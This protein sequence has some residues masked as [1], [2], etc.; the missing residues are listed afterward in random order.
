[1][2]TR[3]LFFTL[4][5]ALNIA[6]T[7]H[8]KKIS[9]TK[10]IVT[11]KPKA[12]KKQ[13]AILP[14]GNINNETINNMSEI[15]KRFYT[16]IEI[17][18]TVNFPA[19]TYYKPRNRYRADSLI[20]WMSRIAKPN[21]TIIGLTNKDISTTSGQYQDWGVMGLG[22]CPGN[23]CVSSSYRLKNKNNFWKVAIHELG[24]T[25]GLPH[26][27]EKTCY[28]RDASGGDPTGEETDFCNKCKAY[29]KT[30]GWVL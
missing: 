2:I 15:I 4:T 6:C 29:L 8:D 24:H 19:S 30:N 20:S 16:D 5:I 21:Q 13:I 27:I 11:Q 3:F 9:P 1:M 7:M 25:T 26:C 23:A 18:P 28:M 12:P 22:F 14:L 17:L 10:K